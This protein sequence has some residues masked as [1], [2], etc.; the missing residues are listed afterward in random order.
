MFCTRCGTQLPEGARFCTSCGVPT[1]AVASGGVRPEGG[2][3]A[4]SPYAGGA[5]AGSAETGS[6]GAAGPQGG[7]G[8]AWFAPAAHRR[9]RRVIARK[10]IAGVCAGF[11]EYFEMDVTLMR[12][13]WVILLVV[14][15]NIA[16][17]AYLI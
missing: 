1:G 13:I 17:I 10:K 8:D 4:A 2:F 6:A 12:L 15:P 5:S 16:V 11:A 7:A 9:L 14:P 3:Y